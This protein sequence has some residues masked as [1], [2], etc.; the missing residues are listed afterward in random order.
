MSNLDR[1]RSDV[2]RLV[3]EGDLLLMSMVLDLFPNEVAKANGK[4][5]EELKKTSQ[6][7]I[8]NTSIGT[9]RLSR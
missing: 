9:L 3:A 6:T 4:K 5:V 2:E 8:R 7:L 1:M